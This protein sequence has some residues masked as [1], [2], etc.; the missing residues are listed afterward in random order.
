MTTITSTVS[1][2]TT[3]ALRLDSDLL[4]AM[5]ELKERVGIPVTTQLEKAARQWLKTEYGVIVKTDRKRPAS[6]KRS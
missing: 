4:D 5:R 2:K 6:R 1:P 3:T